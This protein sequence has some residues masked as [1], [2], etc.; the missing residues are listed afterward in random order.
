[1]IVSAYDIGTHSTR[2]LIA[3]IEQQNI[4]EIYRETNITRLGEGIENK[5]IKKDAINRVSK[6]LGKYY[7]ISKNYNIK[8]SV[9]IAT[10]AVRD[11]KNSDEFISEVKQIID[12]EPQ[13]I[14]GEKEAKFTFTGVCSGF[15]DSLSNKNILVID[16]GGGSTEIIYGTPQ[17]IE[18]IKSYDVGCLRLTEMFFKNDPPN[19]T[20]ILEFLDFLDKSFQDNLESLINKI[21]VPIAVAGTPTALAALKLN[22]IEYDR[23]KV[24][25]T[26]LLLSEINAFLDKFTQS[27]LLERKES[28]FLEPARAEVIIAGTLILKYLLDKLSLNKII[29]SEY[30][31]LDGAAFQALKDCP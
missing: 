24:H 17:N 25:K 26:E 23:S 8:K 7:G 18:F 27:S 16:I 6:I 14:S 30:D 19:Q 4:E 9:C 11:A 13:I 15:D 20:E 10:S 29:V 21:D 2:L 31:I 3:K 28:L 12:I 22:L 5:I 1:M